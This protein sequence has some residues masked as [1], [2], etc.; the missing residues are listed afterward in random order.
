MA[1][2]ATPETGSL[3]QEADVMQWGPVLLT[4]HRV[5]YES[6]TSGKY[7]YTSLALDR[8]DWVGLTRE[9][10]PAVLVLAA[11]VAIVALYFLT[12]NEVTV[13]ALGIVIALV[14]LLA[15][16]AS[17]RV[18]LAIGGGHG[19]ISVIIKGGDQERTKAKRFLDRV[20]EHSLRARRRI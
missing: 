4:N 18:V 14:I 5:R 3:P 20:Q 12:N 19:R 17:R 11:L 8:V 9:H 1:A 13:A 10:Q 16:F 15:Y 7:S 2:P 6:T